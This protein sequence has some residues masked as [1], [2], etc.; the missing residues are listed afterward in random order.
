MTQGDL[1]AQ[2]ILILMGY[3]LTHEAGHLIAGSIQGGINRAFCFGFW[4]KYIP[5]S[6]AI[7]MEFPSDLPK[8]E[9]EAV[10]YCR[11]LNIFIISANMATTL[12]FIAL[13]L[14]GVFTPINT[15]IWIISGMLY[16]WV[17]LTARASM[18]KNM[19]FYA[20][21]LDKPFTPQP[22][23]TDIRVLFK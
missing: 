5:L 2:L 17:E 11:R 21:P 20:I 15:A 3:Y 18:T 6:F 1:L 23:T 9:E 13:Y 8:T 12:Y 19:T 22:S 7:Y 10:S 4:R 16:E 14:V